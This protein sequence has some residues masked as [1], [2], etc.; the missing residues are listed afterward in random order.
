MGRNQRFARLKVAAVE[1]DQGAAVGRPA[2]H[3]G[4]M[5]T[6]LEPGAAKGDI[7]GT[8][9]FKPLAKRSL[10]KSANG[11]RA[12]R[13]NLD[14]VDHVMLGSSMSCMGATYKICQFSA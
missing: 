8:K 1:N 14:I 7:V 9:P 4:A 10:E 2:R 6:T 5:D 11:L 13:G 12:H 3:V